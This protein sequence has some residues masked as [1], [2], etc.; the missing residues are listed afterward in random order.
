MISEA[1]QKGDVASTWLSFLRALALGC[2]PPS[3]GETQATGRSHVCVFWLTAPTGTSRDGKE[4]A[5]R[6]V[7]AATQ[8]ITI[9]LIPRMVMG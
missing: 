8:E 4:G 3:P 1:A 6:G 7:L 9:W 2:Q 5:P